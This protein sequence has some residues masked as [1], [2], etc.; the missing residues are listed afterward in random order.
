[1]FSLSDRSLSVCSLVKDAMDSDIF[2]M[3]MAEQEMGY[4]CP[5]SLHLYSSPGTR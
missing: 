1:L 3:R 2:T 5:D 4:L